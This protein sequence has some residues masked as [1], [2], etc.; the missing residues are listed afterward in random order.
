MLCVPVL[1]WA[2]WAQSNQRWGANLCGQPGRSKEWPSNMSHYTWPHVLPNHPTALGHG[3]QICW[4][5]RCLLQA[6]D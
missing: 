2:R 4:G 6:T 1:T 5:E 3:S